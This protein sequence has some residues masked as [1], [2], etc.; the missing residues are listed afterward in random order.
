MN[1]FDI[2]QRGFWETKDSIG[3]VY[4]YGVSM[5]LVEFLN[6]NNIKSLVDFG[7]GMA[8]YILEIKKCDIY[9]EAYDGNPNTNIL[10]NGLANVLDLSLSFKLNNKFDCVLSLEV[11]EHIPKEY[12]ETFINNICNHTCNFIIL[13]WAIIGQPGDG[14]VNCQENKYII[15][16]IENRGFLYDPKSST[17]FRESATIAHWFKDTIMV[18]KKSDI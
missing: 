12:E 10:T 13:S 17:E 4:D 5:H 1:K 14:H 9:C 16:K 7:C 8:E 3:H 15:N 11:G 6:K 18:F 2:N